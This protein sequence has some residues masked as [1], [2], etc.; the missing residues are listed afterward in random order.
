MERR[1]FLALL[2]GLA[3]AASGCVTN[4]VYMGELADHG[5]A[6]EEARRAI[7][8]WTKSDPVLGDPKAGPAILHT[9]CGRGVLFVERPEGIVFRG[10]PGKDLDP[11]TG[12]PVHDGQI[13]GRFV[14]RQT[15]VD[16]QEGDLRVRISCTARVSEFSAVP[17][18]ATYLP[19]RETPYRF[20]ITRSE[21]SSLF[22]EIPDVPD[23]PAC[24]KRP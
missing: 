20:M 1:V 10:D 6:G 4:T 14:G 5:I 24:D 22:G 7:V 16:L 13:C 8:Y 12:E 23:P 3:L 18:R 2:A 11:R 21:T 15:F 9:A 19:A 17:E